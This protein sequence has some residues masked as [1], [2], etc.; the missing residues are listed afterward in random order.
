MGRGRGER[1]RGGKAAQNLLQNKC[2]RRSPH[3][4]GSRDGENE[5]RIEGEH[6]GDKEE[7]ERSM[8]G[9]KKRRTW[10]AS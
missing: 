5:G 7:T 3:K 4:A 1:T 6:G 2:G 9:E 10:A 8:H